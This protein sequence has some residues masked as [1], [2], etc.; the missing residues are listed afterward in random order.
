MIIKNLFLYVLELSISASFAILIFL[1]LAAFLNRRFPAKWNYFIW[2]FLALWLIFPFQKLLPRQNLLTNIENNLQKEQESRNTDDE[3]TYSQIMV[4]I[5]PQLSTPIVRHPEQGFRISFVDI[6]AVIWLIGSLTFLSVHLIGYVRYK[7]EILKDGSLIE[8]AQI[9]QQLQML[10]DDLQIKK[11]VTVV[12]CS[13]SDCPM[14]VGFFRPTLVLSGELYPAEELFF[15]LKHEL[16]HLKHRDVYRKLFFVI[17]NALHWFNPLV[18]MMCRQAAVDLELACDERVVWNADYHVRKAYAET[19]FASLHRQSSR[20]S[21]LFTQFY[22]G[23]QIMKKRFENILMKTKK[24]NG[25][26]VFVCVAVC[27]TFLGSLAGCS[28]K[29]SFIEETLGSE[30][31]SDLGTTDNEKTNVQSTGK[32]T[33]SEGHTDNE[34]TNAQST[35]KATGSEDR[36]GNEKTNA[37]S[38]AVDA[39]NGGNAANGKSTSTEIGN[40]VN[41]DY[42]KAKEKPAAAVAGTDKSAGI[43]KIERNETNS[44]QRDILEHDNHAASEKTPQNSA[45]TSSMSKNKDTDSEKTILAYISEFDADSRSIMFDEVEWV[46]VP[47]KR[48]A[49]LGVEDQHLDSG[50]YVYNEK[51]DVEK[52][53]LAQSC[54]C[55]VLDWY[56]S[57]APEEVTA[58]EFFGILEERK[59]LEGNIP[60]VLTIRDQVVIEIEEHYVP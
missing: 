50:F 18:W 8:D 26:T 2:T 45:G 23:K 37:Q 33:D 12:K 11:K 10:S 60:Y 19:L 35:G 43:D 20:K 55:T 13:K 49:E 41:A 31:K 53:P 48:A 24:K 22:G 3:K 44:E 7:K 28:V 6:A 30:N 51:N 14:V 1:F 36:E 59:D 42:E 34:K 47:S 38:T 54:K 58:D 52:L 57:Y 27:I 15:I 17:C 16:I 32:A 39:G 25:L 29:E 5:P 46:T 4:E 9:L 40:E 56:S 21:M